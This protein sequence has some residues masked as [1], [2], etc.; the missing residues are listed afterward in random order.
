MAQPKK[1]A[2]IATAIFDGPTDHDFRKQ[3]HNNN[4]PAVHQA[5]K[6]TPDVDVVV[7][8]FADAVKKAVAEH[9][10]NGRPV[11]SID[12]ENKIKSS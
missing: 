3:F 12:S 11:Y 1:P 4:M 2:D 6:A 5:D 9:R 8:G 7:A 10:A